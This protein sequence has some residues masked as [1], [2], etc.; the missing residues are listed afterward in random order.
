MKWKME[1]AWNPTCNDMP[2]GGMFV[3]GGGGFMTWR[4]GLMTVCAT[5]QDF[6]NPTRVYRALIKE[7]S[8]HDNDNSSSG[9]LSI[10]VR[11]RKGFWGSWEQLIEIWKSWE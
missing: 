9:M 7:K 10:N 1:I 5:F 4:Q 11:C 8:L 6:Q 3:I 2:L